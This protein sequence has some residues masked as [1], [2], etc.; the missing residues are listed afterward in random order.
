MKCY[1]CG[2]E[3]DN[4]TSFCQQCGVNLKKGDIQTFNDNIEVLNKEFKVD[5]KIQPSSTPKENSIQ[6]L[7]LYKRDNRSGKL[8][9]AKT[10]CISIA[11]FSA[12]FFFALAVSLWTENI[13]IAFCVSIAFGLMFAVPVAII[14]FIMGWAIDKITH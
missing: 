4:N 2:F 8:R 11:V 7:L 9:L 5:N 14:G 10:K 13:F 6:A 1:N 3:N 12:F